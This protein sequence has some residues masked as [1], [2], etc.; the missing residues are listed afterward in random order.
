MSDGS[1]DRIGIVTGAGRGIGRA[2]ARELADRGLHV[3]AVG[4]GKGP[5]DDT[6]REIRSRGGSADA[7]PLDVADETAVTELVAWIGSSLGGLDVLVNNAGINVVAPLTELGLEDWDRV[8]RTNLT[9]P[10]LLSRA[11]WPLL[12]RRAGA[13]V[14][15]S[16]VGGRPGVPK[17][18]GFA[19]YAA[20]KYGL[21]GLTEIL[22]LEGRPRGIRVYG[23]CP[24][25]VRTELLAATL[26][27]EERALEVEEVA[28]TIAW[29]ALEGSLA[30]SGS[31]VDLWP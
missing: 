20:S 18:P 2:V 22:A 14:N 23:A 25:S 21:L 31:V 17:F 29:L 11:C 19:A 6:V 24:A 12:E 7:R 13:I 30:A 9:G 28:R 4:R 16:S 27:G 8:L 5:L 3:V 15:V 10:F 1:S 26:P